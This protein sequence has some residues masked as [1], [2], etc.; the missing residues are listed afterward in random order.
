MNIQFDRVLSSL[1]RGFLDLLSPR[2][3]LLILIPPILAFV[4]WISL[5]AQVKDFL[6]ILLQTWVLSFEELQTIVQ[7]SFLGWNLIDLV[8]W[9][10]VLPGLFFATWM[11]SVLLVGLFAVPWIRRF[12][13]TRYPRALGGGTGSGGSLLS[14]LRNLLS[15]AFQAI[16]IFFLILLFFWVPGVWP[17]GLFLLAAWVNSRLIFLEVSS[18]VS[19]RVKDEKL[20]QEHKG[21]FLVLG[22]IFGFLFSLP[23]VGFLVPVWTAL[24]F[25]HYL[26]ELAEQTSS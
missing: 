12:L 20:W 8:Y 6:F 10:L 14:S 11:T 21:N 19:L 23:L 2:I 4:L 1:G 13:K 17:I 3:W 9:M 18:E 5:F 24:S 25:F 26:C 16:G 7:V 15:V 22:L